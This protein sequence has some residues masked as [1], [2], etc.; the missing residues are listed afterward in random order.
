[1]NRIIAQVVSPLT[2]SLRFDGALN[3][4]IVTEVD[5]FHTNMSPYPPLHFLLPSFSPLTSLEYAFHDPPSVGDITN[6]AFEPSNMLV[7]CDPRQG[8]YMSCKLL[9]EGDVYPKD[10]NTAIQKIK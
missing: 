6:G 2:S 4:D 5:Y 9:Y 3:I 7:K 10:I 8:K 1:M